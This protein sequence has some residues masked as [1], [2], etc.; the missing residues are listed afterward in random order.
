LTRSSENREIA[1]IRCPKGCK[2]GKGG[3]GG[4]RCK[5]CKGAREASEARPIE[6]RQGGNRE[7]TSTLGVL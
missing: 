1:A 4:L 7:E 2:G 5:G 6:R 3:L